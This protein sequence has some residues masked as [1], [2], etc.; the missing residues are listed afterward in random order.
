MEECSA[1]V[2]GLLWLITDP[3]VKWAGDLKPREH[4]PSTFL[5]LAG[6]RARHILVQLGIT[7]G[8]L[9][10]STCSLV[11]KPTDQFSAPGRWEGP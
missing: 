9:R 7:L 1:R 3:K 6:V 2:P 8:P 10:N 4:W 11:V 5:L